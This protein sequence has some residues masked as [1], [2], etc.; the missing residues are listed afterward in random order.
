LVLGRVHFPD[1][2]DDGAHAGGSKDRD[3]RV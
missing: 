2:S 3:G 1:L